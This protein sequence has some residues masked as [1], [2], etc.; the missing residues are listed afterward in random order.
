MSWWLV[1]W[2]S[3]GRASPWSC[4]CCQPTLRR[5]TRGEGHWVGWRAV[6]RWTPTFIGRGVAGGIATGLWEVTSPP[7]TS[8]SLSEEDDDGLDHTLLLCSSKE[9]SPVPP[10]LPA[11][12]L[13]MVQGQPGTGMARS[14]SLDLGPSWSEPCASW[15]TSG[16]PLHLSVPHFLIC[17]L[18]FGRVRQ[19]WGGRLEHEP[20]TE[21]TLPGCGCF[22][23]E[24]QSEGRGLE[25][26]CGC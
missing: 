11:L 9:T 7:L 12:L 26:G 17:Q 21:Q 20:G 19:D 25:E 8:V 14:L 15:L 16:K 24:S 18:S 3:R 5:R 2:A 23:L 13:E 4:R 6:G 22:G 1:C 10:S